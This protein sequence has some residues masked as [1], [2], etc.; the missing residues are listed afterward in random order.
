MRDRGSPRQHHKKE[1]RGINMLTTLSSLPPINCWG[2]LLAREQGSPSRVVHRGQ[3]P[4]PESRVRRVE[5]IWKSKE[6][7]SSTDINPSCK[8]LSSSKKVQHINKYSL[9]SFVQ[10]PHLQILSTHSNLF[11]TTKSRFAAL[12]Q[13]FHD[14][15]RLRAVKHLSHSTHILS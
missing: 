9:S 6:K 13:S 12:S 2:F 4:G 11:V 15:F 5:W 7:M 14:T 8:T 10:I 1:T 3:S